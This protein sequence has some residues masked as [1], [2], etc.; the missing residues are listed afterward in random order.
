[1]GGSGR[2]SDTDG[3]L[4]AAK[5]GEEWALTALYR[6]HQPALLQF[7]WGLVGAA[8]EDVAAETWIAIARG[9]H[10]FT[11]DERA[12]RRLLFTIGRRRAVD[13]FRAAGRHRLVLTDPMRM[14]E[15][16]ATDDA[17]DAVVAADS[18]RLAARRIGALLPP[19]QAEVVL[20]RVVAGLSVSDVADVVGRSRAAVSVL[21]SRGLE[22][23]ARYLGDGG[24][25]LVPTGAGVTLRILQ[26][27]DSPER[28][29]G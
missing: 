28:R 26:D 12:L 29:N 2:P 20:L 23:L 5:S 6:Q 8:A 3:L 11:G 22:R 9:L 1:M 18:A 7:L 17:A 19:E 15:G 10:R 27:P 21:Q 16:P 13:H 25:D 4:A 24:V 14:P